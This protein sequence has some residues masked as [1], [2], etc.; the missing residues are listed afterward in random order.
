M[1]E[2]VAIIPARSGSKTVKDKNILPLMGY[3]VIAYSIAVALDSKLIS[4]TIVSTDSAE[5][6]KIAEKYGADVPFLRPKEIS[7]DAST[8]RDFMLHAMHWYKETMNYVPEFWVHLRPTTPL[9]RVEI[10]DEAIERIRGSENATSLRSGHPSPESPLKWF[11]KD[12]HGYF[13]ALS[14]FGNTVEAYNLPKEHFSQVFIP[15]GYVDVVRA[16]HVMNNGTLHGQ[17]MLGFESPVCTEIDS[18]EEL[19][20]LEYQINKFGSPLL[21]KMSRR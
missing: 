19:Y 13:R 15:D 11:S 2:V 9:R 21:D 20:F 6:A 3:P 18:E 1:H 10:V 17:Y 5:Y 14:D 4:H 16:S 12:V 7:T 8:D